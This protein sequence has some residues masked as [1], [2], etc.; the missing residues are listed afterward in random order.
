MKHIATLF[1]LLAF[2]SVNAQISL[3][4]GKVFYDISYQNL[5]PEMK[6]NEHMMPH[7]ASFYFSGNKTR[8]EMGVAGMGK[9][10]TLYDRLKKETIVLLYLK[11]K[12]FALVQSD[13][14][15]AA[16]RNQLLADSSQKTF[17]IEITNEYKI[18]CEHKC[19][20]AIVHKTELGISR[21]NECWYTT[22]IAPYNTENDPIL[23]GIEG[24]MLEYTM[25]ENGTT[26]HLKAKMILPVPID[27][28]LF[29]IPSSYQIVNE[30]E[31]TLLLSV[32]QNPSGGQ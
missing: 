30:K 23:K 6:R 12:K 26:M 31:L 22:D 13:S 24:F 19:R 21:T 3:T 7:D 27:K 29:E 4:E 25:G 11:G 28:S 18:I 14:S 9:N 16:I 1:F 10:S 32:M 15:M 8:L 5:A 20:K 17:S 2:A